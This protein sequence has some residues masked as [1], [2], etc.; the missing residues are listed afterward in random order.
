MV[1]FKYTGKDEFGK[2]HRKHSTHNPGM[3]NITKYNRYQSITDRDVFASLIK[4]CCRAY[5]ET[6]TRTTL[7]VRKHICTIA[8]ESTLGISLRMW[9]AHNR[10]SV[11]ATY[12]ADAWSL[13]RSMHNDGH[14]LLASLW[15]KWV[16]YD[17]NQKKKKKMQQDRMEY[18]TSECI[19]YNGSK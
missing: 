3:L 10:Q 4:Y 6:H 14:N 1:Y 8:K 7:L 5:R 18:Q 19:T 17:Q 16:D 12:L 11:L 13:P 2:W 9:N 15:N